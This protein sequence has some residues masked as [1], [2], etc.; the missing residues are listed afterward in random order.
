MSILEKIKSKPGAPAPSSESSVIVSAPLKPTVK[1]QRS[2]KFLGKRSLILYFPNSVGSSFCYLPLS[3]IHDSRIFVRESV[4][5]YSRLSEL[6]SS[7]FESVDSKKISG[8]IVFDVVSSKTSKPI[9]SMRTEAEA[10]EV[11]RLISNALAPSRRKFW[12]WVAGAALLYVV[13]SSIS[14][15]LS[16]GYASAAKP[17]TVSQLPP[18]LSISTPMAVARVAPAAPSTAPVEKEPAPV[19]NLPSA[20]IADESD[21]FGLQIGP[22]SDPFN[23]PDLAEPGVIDEPV[24]DAKGE[25]PAPA[26]PA[27][28]AVPAVPALPAKK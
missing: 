16:S 26:A 22:S 7:D 11:I 14:S 8:D 20:P 21:P 25:A 5:E 17:S 10:S 28:P 18:Q 12:T 19:L 23:N 4:Q 24:L 1:L 13:I 27:A 3:S 9:I 6:G 15:G 2:F